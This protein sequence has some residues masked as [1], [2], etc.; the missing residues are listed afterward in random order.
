MHLRPHPLHTQ[1]ALLAG[2]ALPLLLAVDV[3]NIR[4]LHPVPGQR[5]LQVIADNKARAVAVRQNDETPFLRQPPE[6]GYLLAV[7]EH[8]KAAQRHYRG[9]H[10]LR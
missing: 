6:K 3:R 1:L 9:V 8:G 7:I 2:G 4:L 10:H 5:T